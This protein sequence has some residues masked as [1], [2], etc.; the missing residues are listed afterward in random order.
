MI[1]AVPEKTVLRIA[2]DG[3]KAV[4]RTAPVI[5]R[6]TQYHRATQWPITRKVSPNLRSIDRK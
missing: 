6:E 3:T 1:A 2:V 4:F 5:E